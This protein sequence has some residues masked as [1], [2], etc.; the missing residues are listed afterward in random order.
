MCRDGALLSLPA[1][2]SLFGVLSNGCPP[3]SCFPLQ[4]PF[5]LAPQPRVHRASWNPEGFP[6]PGCWESRKGNGRGCGGWA[7]RTPALS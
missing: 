1:T 5:Q 4:V 6:G 2:H 7:E 3:V